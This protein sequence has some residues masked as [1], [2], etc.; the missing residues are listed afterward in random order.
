MNSVTIIK[1]ENGYIVAC[2]H[3]DVEYIYIYPTYIEALDK[4]ADLLGEC[5]RVEDLD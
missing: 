1:A 3:C 5:V 2:E 4:Q